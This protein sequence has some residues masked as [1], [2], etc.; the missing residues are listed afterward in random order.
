MQTTALKP[1]KQHKIKARKKNRG[2][3]EILHRTL[4][5]FLNY[6]FH[7]K[8]IDRHIYNVINTIS[9]IP[10]VALNTHEQN[11]ITT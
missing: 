4:H 9:D 11:V 7:Q 8:K 10:Q 1:Q 6:M 3:A 5:Y 2:P